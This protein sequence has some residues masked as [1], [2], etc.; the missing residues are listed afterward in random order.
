MKNEMDFTISGNCGLSKFSPNPLK[1]T[2]PLN[3]LFA[4][5]SAITSA[6]LTVM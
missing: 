2:L 3:E 1:D 6:P 5:S 4:S